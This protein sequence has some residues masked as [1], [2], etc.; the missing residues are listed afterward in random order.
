MGGVGYYRLWL[1]KLAIEHDSKWKVDFWG[2]EFAKEIDTKN[3]ETIARS[4]VKFFQ[5][6]D[7]VILKHFDNPNAGRFMFFASEYTGTPII[8]DLD[9]DVLSVREDQPAFKKGYDKG[10]LQ[11]SIVGTMLSFSKGL[12]CTNDYLGKKITSEVKKIFNIDLPYFVLPNYCNP[13][14]WKFPV[15]TNKDRIVIGW[16]GSLTHDADLQMVLPHIKKI[17]EENENVY[18]ELLGGVNAD[19]AIK[20][21]KDWANLIDRIELIAGTKAWHNFPYHLCKQRWDIGIAPLID[22]EF[23]RSKSNIKWLE[24]SLKGIPTVAS[25]V[26][27]YK[28][29][30]H[31]KNGFLVK[32]NEWYGTLTELIKNASL[33][34]KIAKQA[35][36][37]VE[38]QWSYKG[39][40]KLW[41][42]AV[43]SVLK[44]NH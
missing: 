7:A 28:N 5:K 21:F 10:G 34:G 25:D 23:N 32:E 6:Y 26:E 36:S 13:D 17:M 30:K 33:R 1:P 14:E 44:S 42:N 8:T 24:Y 40:G 12:F 11:R 9:D 27:P 39:K 41:R 22:D 15:K 18:L 31:G 29:I 2:T 19:F 43:N 35:L 37:D 38:K 4:Y 16:H 3:Q 20:H